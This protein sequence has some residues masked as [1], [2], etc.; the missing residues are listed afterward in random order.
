MRATIVLENVRVNL[1]DD[2]MLESKLVLIDVTAEAKELC[3]LLSVIF[4]LMVLQTIECLE[5]VQVFCSG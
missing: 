4:F 5:T 2:L 3:Y 1:V